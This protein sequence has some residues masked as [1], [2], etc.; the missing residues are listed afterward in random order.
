[1]CDKA[2]ESEFFCPIIDF[3]Q[4]LDGKVVLLI[5]KRDLKVASRKFMSVFFLLGRYGL[6]C[7]TYALLPRLFLTNNL[8][9]TTV[10]QN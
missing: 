4:L 10:L 1:M 9:I 7:V 8:L 5:E 2:R 3:I 6:H